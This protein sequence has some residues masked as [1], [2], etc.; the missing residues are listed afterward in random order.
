MPTASTNSVDDEDNKEDDSCVEEYD[1]DSDI[2]AGASSLRSFGWRID[3]RKLLEWSWG[4]VPM[5]LAGLAAVLSWAST[6]ELPVP[7][8]PD[9]T[10]RTALKQKPHV[11]LLPSPSSPTR[12]APAQMSEF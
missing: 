7:L 9:H 10:I 11:S 5:V 4:D 3:V 1:G 6:P 2:T 8:A 12:K